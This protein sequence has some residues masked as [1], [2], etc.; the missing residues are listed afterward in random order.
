MNTQIQTKTEAQ[1]SE[2]KF[3]EQ[4]AVYN[5]FAAELGLKAVKKFRDKSTGVSRIMDI[6]EQYVEERYEILAEQKAKAVKKVEKAVDKD[7]NR[8]TRFD[9]S[10]IIT[11][12][13]DESKEGTI[14]NSLHAAIASGYTTAGEIVD[15]LVAT[16]KRPRS[17]LG[18]DEQYVVHNIKWFIKKGHLKSVQE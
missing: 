3:S 13:K 1:I 14:E 11:T 9:M 12:V 8:Q 10:L 6:Q 7:T 18:V 17:G 5:E 15:H 2:L 4:A 16:H